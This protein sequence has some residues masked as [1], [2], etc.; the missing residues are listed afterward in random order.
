M[1]T[2]SPLYSRLLKGA[3]LVA[4]A[5]ILLPSAIDAQ[6][7]RGEAT[8]IPWTI[9]PAIAGMDG[10]SELF[11]PALIF[12]GDRLGN[13]SIWEFSFGT[14]SSSTTLTPGDGLPANVTGIWDLAILS[15]TEVIG[16]VTYTGGGGEWYGFIRSEDRGESWTLITPAS[17]QDEHFASVEGKSAGIVDWTGNLFRVPLY[18]MEWLEDGM[19]G[20]AWGAQG[21]V[22]TTDG[23]STWSIAY[24]TQATAGSLGNAAYQPMWG[25]AM[26]N[27]E[28]G[29]AVIGPRVSSYYYST[30]DGGESWMKGTGLQVTTLAELETVGGEYRSLTFSSQQRG[31]NTFLLVSKD[32]MNWTPKAKLHE[33][34]ASESTYS[35]EM[36]WTSV[37]D[38]FMIQRQGEI[39]RTENGGTTWTLEQETDSQYDTVLF[40]DGTS[41]AGNFQE[42]FYPYAGY[43]Q[44]TIAIRDDFGD[45]YLVNVITDTCIGTIRNYIPVWSVSE[46]S[47]VPTGSGMSALDLTL[48][49][50]PAADRCQVRFTLPESTDLSVSVVD[51]AGKTVRQLDLGHRGAGVQQL[52]LGFDDLPAGTYR[53]RISGDQGESSASIVIGTR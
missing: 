47:S 3:A 28:E 16:L 5:F 43:A 15:D 30:T 14:L 32:G 20:W 33:D 12:I 34:V 1:M 39:W 40:G 41:I 23:G 37:N 26:R 18:E 44:R 49:P 4:A 31:D 46:F 24:E 35:S 8:E 53:V 38:G 29:V 22:R 9:P 52:E 17:L 21:V 19:H 48:L 51:V 45:P 42:P 7:C 25:L 6:T 13:L 36:V 50:N 11:E 2:H 27:A 10:D